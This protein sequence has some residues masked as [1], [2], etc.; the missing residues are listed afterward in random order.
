MSQ[1]AS[2]HSRGPQHLVASV[3]AGLVLASAG[4][5][6]AAGPGPGAG[7]GPFGGP[8][9]AMPGSGGMIEH[10]LAS[11]KDRLALD[12]SQQVAFDR[13]TA[14]MKQARDQ[15]IASRADVRAKVDAELA[16]PEPDL[17]AVSDAFDTAEDQGRASRRALRDQ[18]LAFYANLRPDQKALVRDAI[19]ERV[20]SMD[21]R[22]PS[23]R[24]RMH[25][26]QS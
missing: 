4:V 15:A 26:R 18:W 13:I 1:T 3:F 22:H 19:R 25:R 11:L 9:G 24:D 7:R 8:T 6:F 5:A 23:M 10:V 21:D 14:Q 20:A 12:T 16:K 17:A 2:S